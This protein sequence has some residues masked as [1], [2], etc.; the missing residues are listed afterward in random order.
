MGGHRTQGRDRRGMIKARHVASSLYA[1]VALSAGLMLCAGSDC[2]R[3]QYPERPLRFVIPFPPGGGADNLARIVGQ[4]AG[5]R[6]AQQVVIDNRA[7]AGGNIA[8][9]TVA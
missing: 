4:S 2:A 7:G 5:E 3:A 6:L 1:C 9:E 8:A